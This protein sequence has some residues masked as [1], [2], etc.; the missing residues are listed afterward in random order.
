MSFVEE[1]NEIEQHIALFL[2]QWYFSYFTD[3]YREVITDQKL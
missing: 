3:G 2:P 1:E